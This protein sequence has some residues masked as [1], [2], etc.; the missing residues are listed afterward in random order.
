MPRRSASISVDIPFLEKKV[1]NLQRRAP[2][3]VDRGLWAGIQ[4]ATLDVADRVKY[5]IDGPVLHRRTGRL[6]RSIQAETFRRFGRIVGIVGTD[7][8]YAAVHEFGATIRPKESGGRLVFEV[9]GEFRSV[10]SVEIPKRPYM[11]RAFKERKATVNKLIRDH[12]MRSVRGQLQSGS[13]RV[14]PPSLRRGVGFA[15]PN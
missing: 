3:A 2:L 7:V 9:D 1:A 11:S 5:L 4:A 12:V 8:E 13:S 15:G 14:L 10:A 6:W